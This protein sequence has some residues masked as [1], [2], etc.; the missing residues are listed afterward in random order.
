M[1]IKKGQNVVRRDVSGS[2]EWYGVQ[3]VQ[4]CGMFRMFRMFQT[5]P[6]TDSATRNTSYARVCSAHQ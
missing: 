4:P 6:L 1:K 3:Q 5:G 2:E